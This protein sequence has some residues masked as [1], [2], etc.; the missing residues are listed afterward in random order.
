MFLPSSTTACQLPKVFSVNVGHVNH[1]EMQTLTMLVGLAWAYCSSKSDNVTWQVIQAYVAIT[2]Q[3]VI[4]SHASTF[5]QHARQDACGS[6]NA[7]AVLPSE[8]VS[9]SQVATAWKCTDTV[10]LWSLNPQ[11]FLCTQSVFPYSLII[12]GLPF[13]GSLNACPY[14]RQ[15][16]RKERKSFAFCTVIN[17]SSHTP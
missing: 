8:F 15:G 10:H 16:A 13:S 5:L 11:L 14:R 2:R 1:L 6:E 7:V 9:S 3:K 4:G 12:T 17:P